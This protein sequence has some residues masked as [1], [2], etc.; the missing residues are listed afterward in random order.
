MEFQV[1][2]LSSVQK[3]I[4]VVVE[5]ERVNASLDEAY[6]KM[7]RE[8]RMKG[9]RPG[10]V[11]RKLLEKRFSRHVEGEVSSLLISEAF[12]EAIKEHELAPVSQPII[13]KTSLRP[14]EAYSF[15]VTIEVQP[16]IELKTWEGIEVEWERAEVPNEQVEQQVEALL[17]QNAI[18][19][20]AEEGHAADDRDL[21][22]LNARLEAEGQEPFSLDSL[23]VAVGQP[24]G[25]PVADWLGSLVNGMKVGDT[26]T[27]EGVDVPPGT[28][29]EA[30]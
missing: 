26:R 29:G 13:E 14:G 23:M 19:E 20:A 30:W 9:F 12:E 11:P 17:D 3:K 21:V 1:E 27:D 15:S 24:M 18:V 6:R 5:S 28:V 22:L 25:I 16:E 7:S 2:D 10:K 8:V 4:S